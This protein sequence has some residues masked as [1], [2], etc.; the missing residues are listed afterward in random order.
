MFIPFSPS[1]F[2]SMQGLPT[3]STQNKLFGNENKTNDHTQKT[4]YVEK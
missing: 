3:L 1:W 2:I 4:I